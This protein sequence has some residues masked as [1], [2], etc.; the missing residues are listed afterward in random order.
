MFSASFYLILNSI[1]QTNVIV[2]LW[3]HFHLQ[4]GILY[5]SFLTNRCAA[6]LIWKSKSKRTK[7]CIISLSIFLM[8]ISG[9]ISSTVT[10]DAVSTRVVLLSGLLTRIVFT[11]S[12]IWRQTAPTI[13]L[14]PINGIT[15]LFGMNTHGLLQKVCVLLLHFY[16]LKNSAHAHIFKEHSEEGS[17][18]V[19]RII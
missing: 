5:K 1:Y 16:N 3:K 19:L 13:C 12:I 7:T 14:A 10:N 18:D 2:N 9:I 15:F 8:L 6:K 17:I 4:F 11:A